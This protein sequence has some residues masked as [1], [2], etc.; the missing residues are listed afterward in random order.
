MAQPAGRLHSG[1]IDAIA[2]A[3]DLKASLLRMDDDAGVRFAL[4]RGLTITGTLGVL[5]EAA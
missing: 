5:V 1:K 3:E 2:L 4:A